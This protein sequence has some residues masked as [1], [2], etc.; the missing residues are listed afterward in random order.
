MTSGLAEQYI[1]TEIFSKNIFFLCF[2]FTIL[3]VLINSY[4]YRC[5][6]GWGFAYL[7]ARNPRYPWAEKV[8]DFPATPCF[9]YDDFQWMSIEGILFM[10]NN[11]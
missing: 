6:P 1:N 10:G 5:E 8:K 11:F 2:T 9:S 7:L 3:K 4:V